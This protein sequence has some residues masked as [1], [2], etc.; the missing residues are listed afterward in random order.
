MPD[1]ATYR[2]ACP[3]LGRE[4]EL[5]AEREL[6]IEARHPDLPPHRRTTLAKV[7]A[8]P[9]LVRRGATGSSILLFSRWYTNVGRGR[10]IVVVVVDETR[11]PLRSWIVSLHSP[12][13]P[14]RGGLVAAKLTFEYDRQGDILYITSCPPYAEQESEELGDDV[15]ARLNPET[16]DIESLEILSFSTRLKD[17]PFELPISAALRRAG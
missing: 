6:H 15:I 11:A 3:W 1:P 5:T 14:R 4:V 13:D 16:G 17:A 2:F 12:E 10:H 7:L 9:D 8:D